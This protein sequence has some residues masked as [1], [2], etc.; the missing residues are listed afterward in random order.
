MARSGRRRFGQRQRS[1]T[2]GIILVLACATAC[3]PPVPTGPTRGAP[4]VGDPYLP[5]SGNGGYDV[6]HYGLTIRYD[7]ARH[8]INGVAAIDARTTQRLSQFDLDLVGLTVRKVAV[9]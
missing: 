6:A 1:L 3:V 5:L 8:F 4:G 2:L 7:P 9:Q